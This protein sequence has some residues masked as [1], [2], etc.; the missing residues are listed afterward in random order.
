[1]LDIPLVASLGIPL[2]VAGMEIRDFLARLGWWNFDL[3]KKV[4]AFHEG[5]SCQSLEC[6]MSILGFVRELF[7]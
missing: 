2:N 1:M 4:P 3:T 7:S 5:V 6:L